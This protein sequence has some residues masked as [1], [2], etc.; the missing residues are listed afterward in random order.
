MFRKGYPPTMIR[1]EDPPKEPDPRG[2]NRYRQP[3]IFFT[4]ARDPTV[5]VS[6]E[7]LDSSRRSF[8][9]AKAKWTLQANPAKVFAPSNLH[10]SKSMPVE[11][12]SKE[13]VAVARKKRMMPL[14]EMIREW[15]RSPLSVVDPNPCS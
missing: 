8:L 13:E 9:S 4:L 7:F 14:Q 15:D 5:Y 1:I 11:P 3:T 6:A 12:P 2:A 10:F